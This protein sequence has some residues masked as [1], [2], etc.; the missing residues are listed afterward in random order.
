M[1]DEPNRDY[2]WRGIKRD[3]TPA[4]GVMSMTESHLASVVED[5][6]KS[7]WVILIVEQNGREV[8]R[9]GRNDSG[10]R[11]WWAEGPPTAPI[12]SDE[13][14]A[15]LRDYLNGQITAD[16]A[17][18]QGFLAAGDLDSAAPFGGLLSANRS[19]LAKMHELEAEQ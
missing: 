15:A 6:F 13:R 7:G 8:A 10:K 9:I 2:R 18:H 5:R 3:G 14:W 12:T 16:A 11:T 4:T 19:T 17:T 1:T